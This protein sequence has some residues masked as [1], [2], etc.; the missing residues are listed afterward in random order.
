MYNLQSESSIRLCLRARTIPVS[1]HLSNRKYPY[2]HLLTDA[3]GDR[4]CSHSTRLCAPNDAICTVS[5]F[6]EELSELSRFARTRLTD[7]HQ[8]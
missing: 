7:D 1:L 6:V 4:H 3:L 2:L 8:N 5:V